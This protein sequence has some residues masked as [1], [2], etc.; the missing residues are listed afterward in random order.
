[1]CKSVYLIEPDDTSRE[2]LSLIFRSEGFDV[3][4]SCRSIAEAAIEDLDSDV[5]AIVDC[6]GI[7]EQSEAIAKLKSNSSSIRVAV[8]ADRLDPVAMVSC[9]QQGAEGYIVKSKR[10]RPMIA[11]LR[12]FVA[13]G[14]TTESTPAASLAD[15]ISA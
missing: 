7:G 11:A 15:R 3:V 12:Q 9:F 13:E 8:L 2:A 4:G 6:Q 5:L 14:R 10:A 1:M